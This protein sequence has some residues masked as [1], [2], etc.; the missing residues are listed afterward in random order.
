MYRTQQN[1]ASNA[2]PS[3]VGEAWHVCRVR[4]MIVFVNIY[5]LG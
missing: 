2:S 4:A 5:C 3:S 1:P